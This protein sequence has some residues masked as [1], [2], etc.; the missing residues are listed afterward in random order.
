MGRVWAEGPFGLGP[1]AAACPQLLPDHLPISP[2]SLS[3]GPC[4]PNPCHSDAECHVIDDFHRGDVF[5]QYIC[6]CPHGYTGIHCEIGEY[7]GVPVPG[8]RP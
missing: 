1:S 4:F 7:L 2:A 8:G 5:T 6:K 3:P